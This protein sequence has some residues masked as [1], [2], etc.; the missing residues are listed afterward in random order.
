MSQDERKKEG[1]RVSDPKPRELREF[2]FED[3]L[4]DDLAGDIVQTETP[5]E[6]AA[7][8]AEDAPSPAPEKKKKKKAK[9]KPVLSEEEAARAKRRKHRYI[10]KR[11]WKISTGVLTWVKD[12]AIA[13]AIIWVVQMF[14]AGYVKVDNTAMDPTIQSGETIVYSRFSY[15]FSDPGRGEIIAFLVGE[16]KRAHISRVIGLPGDVIMIDEQGNIS[17]NGIAFVTPYCEGT[18]TYIPGQVTYPYTVPEDSYFVL[19]DNPNATLDSRFVSVS[20]VPKSDI[21]GKVFFCVWPRQSW[22][23]IVQGLIS[24]SED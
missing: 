17:V 8:E 23:P 16:S 1:E 14:I 3:I 19:C 5:A 4:T 9:N 6:P 22:R 18:T 24:L 10:R 13:V 12:I 21:V 15:R 11:L 7:E 2:D 20:A